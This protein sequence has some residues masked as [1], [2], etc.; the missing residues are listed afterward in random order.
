MPEPELTGRII[1]RL[2]QSATEQTALA[3]ENNLRDVADVYGLT[4]LATLLDNFAQSGITP[5][6]RVIQSIDMERLIQ[7]EEEAIH[8]QFPPRHSLAGYWYLEASDIRAPNIAQM[9]VAL[10]DEQ[11]VAVA[12]K[13]ASSE[14]AS[15]SY[16]T[17]DS[18]QQEYLDDAPLGISA[19]HLWEEGV[20]GGVAPPV[21][22]PL[23]FADLEFDWHDLHNDLPKARI[24]VAGGFQRIP[25]SGGYDRY[26]GTAALGVV[27]AMHNDACV[28]GI[29]PDVP[30]VLLIPAHRAGKQCI[31]DSVV[32]AIDEG[33]KPGDVLLIELQYVLAPVEVQVVH[34]D[35]V[36]LASA[37]GIVVVELAGNGNK[38][39]AS[40]DVTQDIYGFLPGEHPFSLSGVKNGFDSG[41]IIVGACRKQVITGPE[42]GHCFRLGSNGGTRVDCYAWGEDVRTTGDKDNP[43]DINACSDDF[44]STSAASAIVAGATLLLQH[45][46]AKSTNGWRL[47]PGQIR[48]LYRTVGTPIYAGSDYPGGLS[49]YAVIGYMPDLKAFD[50]ELETNPL[51]DV[52][53]RDYVGDSGH[54]PSGGLLSLSPDVIVRQNSDPPE[55]FGDGS[56]TEDSDT[57]CQNVLDNR[58]N[59]VYVRMRNRGTVDAVDTRVSVYWSRVS[60]LVLPED[61]QPISST[62][63]V[64]PLVPG[65]HTSLVV[66]GPI[67]WSN[68]PNPGHYCFI[69]VLD[70]DADPAPPIPAPI[71]ADPNVDPGISWEDFLSFIRNNNNVTWRN[72][73][74]IPVAS[75]LYTACPPFIIRGAPDFMREFAFEFRFRLPESARAVLEMPVDL[76]DRLRH[77]FMKTRRIVNIDFS[78]GNEVARLELPAL[79]KVTIPAV[80]LDRNAEFKCKLIVSGLARRLTLPDDGTEITWGRRSFGHASVSVRQVYDGQPVGGVTWRFN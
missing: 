33:L 61:W 26:H 76:A 3:T 45:K 70:N 15:Y 27:I 49:D 1:L 38:D 52:Y 55:D 63:T 17:T 5:G 68:P 60:T 59:Y 56:G 67:V 50:T 71:V 42:E 79:R 18:N 37:L 53:L 43:D 54:V 2:S 22:L 8:S 72:F 74:V 28:A 65:N 13:E 12:Y 77:P 19:R 9:L 46:Y 75:S 48:N 11:H 44:N 66:A 47:T 29:A 24:S 21:G 41:A 40:I 36:R 14:V 23:T 7:L 16:S 39:L 32:A 20:F 64:A 10:N 57:L 73:N 25:G 62:P 6:G 80:P 69:A 51:P 30:S 78:D 4:S 31:A 35:A 58:D 34:F